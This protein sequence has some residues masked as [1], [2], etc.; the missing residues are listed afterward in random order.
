MKWFKKKGLWFSMGLEVLCGLVCL[1]GGLAVIMG[2]IVEAV[3]GVAVLGVIALIAAGG[4][5]SA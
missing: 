3:V 1:L 4:D 2:F 5:I